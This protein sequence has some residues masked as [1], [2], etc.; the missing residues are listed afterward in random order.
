LAL[1]VDEEDIAGLALKIGNQIVDALSEENRSN[2]R[3]ELLVTPILTSPQSKSPLYFPC[4]RRLLGTWG[5]G[6]GRSVRRE[7]RGAATHV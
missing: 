5:M 7:G 6:R 1:G 3:G 4:H 2:T